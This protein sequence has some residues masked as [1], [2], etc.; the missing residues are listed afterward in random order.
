[1][2]NS[3]LPPNA[4]PLERAFELSA[5]D[6]LE[7]IDLPL[8]RL[9][10]PR[11]CPAELLPF[12][13]W[14]WNTSRWEADWSEAEKR[15]VVA[16]AI[17]IARIK[18]SRACVE[19]VMARHDALAYLVEWWEE[20]PRGEPGTFTVFLPLDAAGG[21]RATPDFARAIIEDVIRHKPLS[22]HFI[23]AYRL[24]LAARIGAV[25]AVRAT[26]FGRLDM[27]MLDDRSRDW[28]NFL[29]TE[30]GEPLETEDGALL[31]IA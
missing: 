4:T 31:E 30:I 27:A 24:P 8:D 20:Q 28:D 13:A 21:V 16:D 9:K 3:L 12:L 6:R 17:R 1:M 14:E 7:A 18:G 10:D 25:A 22:A 29:T 2:P 23:F 15:D 19:E 11:T 5:A 26:L